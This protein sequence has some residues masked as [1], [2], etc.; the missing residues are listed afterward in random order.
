MEGYFGICTKYGTETL[1]DDQ[2]RNFLAQE[3]PFFPFT[4]FRE[5][6]LAYIREA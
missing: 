4:S 6:S 2:T 1:E 3:S 5:L